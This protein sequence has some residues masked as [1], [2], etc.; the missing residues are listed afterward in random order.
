MS[1][2]KIPAAELIAALR[3]RGLTLSCAE[4]CTGG[5]FAKCTVDTPGASAVFCGGVV[6]YATE[7]KED[8]LRV[9]HST[10]EEN[11]VYSTA[12]AC[13]MAE[14]VRKLMKTDLSVS[15][16]GVAGP[17]PQD[18]KPVGYVCIGISREGLTYAKECMFRGSRTA[19]RRAAVRKMFE[20]LL[21]DI[22]ENTEKGDN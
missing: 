21:Q 4:S 7:V 18:G 19:I 3:A 12:V 11:T 6:S 14:G 20:I 13:E 9:R 5:W 16:T 17:D 2:K 15:V 8:V 22:S 1:Y 10:V